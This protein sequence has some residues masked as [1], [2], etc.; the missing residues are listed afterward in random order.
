[1]IDKEMLQVLREELQRLHEIVK[2]PDET[3]GKGRKKSGDKDWAKARIAE[4][5]KALVGVA[6]FVHMPVHHQAK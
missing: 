3:P 6:T 2:R 1:M 4:L 5:Q